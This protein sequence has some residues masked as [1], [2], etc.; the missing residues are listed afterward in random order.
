MSYELLVNEAVARLVRE[1]DLEKVILFGSRARGDERAD[2]DVDLLVV[3]S[4]EVIRQHGR[5]R[6]LARFWSA[7]GHLPVSFDFLLFSPDEITQWQDSI[8][9]VISRA[10]REGRVVYE[11]A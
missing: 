10:M 4:E 11:R 3:A 6:L 9:H 1:V 2:S 5:R 7:M 8:N